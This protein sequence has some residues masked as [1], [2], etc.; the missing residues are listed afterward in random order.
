[1]FDSL[2]IRPI[3]IVGWLCLAAELLI[4]VV[5]LVSRN[6]GD[7]AAGR[8]FATAYGAVLAPIVL[9]VG[10][11]LL[12]GT[13]TGSRPVIVAGAL[14]AALPFLAMLT[15][16]AR[17]MLQR[18]HRARVGAMQGAFASD[19]LTAL[20]RAI[21]RGDPAEVERMVRGLTANWGERDKFNRTLLGHAVV[22]ARETSATDAHTEIVRVLLDHGVPYRADALEPESDWAALTATSASDG[23]IALLEVALKH[24][25]DPNARDPW[26][27]Q[28]MLFARGI[29]PAKAD[30]LIRFGADVQRRAARD[31]RREWTALMGALADGSWEMAHYF[32]LKRVPVDYVAPDGRSVATLLAEADDLAKRLGHSTNESA[33]TFRRAMR[34]V[35][36][37]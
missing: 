25:A 37:K 30:L 14:L 10:G 11:T 27:N 22:R 18:I 33:E 31:D 9:L 26:D 20:A 23:G 6:M 17:G 5:L 28:P 3:L 36:G 21:D 32:L 16:G 24:G 34:E 35:A 12:W 2:P 19:T 8:G 4:V 15:L 13:R 7:D 29:T 1:M